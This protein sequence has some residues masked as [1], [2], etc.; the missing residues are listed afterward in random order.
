MTGRSFGLLDAVLFI[1]KHNSEN[2][3]Q[4]KLYH[5][6]THTEAPDVWQT[7]YFTAHNYF[8]WLAVN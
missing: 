1:F 8:H 6:R 4:Q 2:N 7:T 3:F 5:T